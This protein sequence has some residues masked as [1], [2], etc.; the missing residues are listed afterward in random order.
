[1]R[2]I[3]RLILK[4]E[5]HRLLIDQIACAFTAEVFFFVKKLEKMKKL[6]TQVTER[7]IKMRP[8]FVRRTLYQRPA[9]YII[10]K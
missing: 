8:V 1:M 7:R 9:A 3:N 6:F 5:N 2:R 4:S 10:L